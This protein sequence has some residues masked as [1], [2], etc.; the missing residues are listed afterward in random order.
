MLRKEEMKG[1]IK[2]VLFRRGAPQ[3]FH[4]L[5]VD[6]NIVFY[7]ATVEKGRRVSK[8]LTDYEN[9]SGQKLNKEK[10]SLYFNKNT[11][12]ETQ[13]Q[14][15]TLIGAQI[16]HYHEKYLG[17]PPLVGR[18]KMRA[19]NRIKDQVGRK[20]VGW[21]GKLLSNA[22]REVLIKAVAQVTPIYTMS[23]FKI[24]DSLCKELN[25]MMSRFR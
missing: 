20:I 9:D 12:R 7:R 14:V 19:F 21:K 1:M 5:F 15:K 23:C 22:G 11:S 17:P 10:T 16:I 8:I 6:D 25:L 3:V 18:E 13:E 4:L 24:L 2:G